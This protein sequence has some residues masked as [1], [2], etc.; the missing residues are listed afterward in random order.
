MTLPTPVVQRLRVLLPGGQIAHTL[1]VIDSGAMLSLLQ[2]Q[3]EA[4]E[5]VVL[6]SPSVNVAADAFALAG[7]VDG[8]IVIASG[9]VKE[10][11]SMTC[12]A[13]STRLTRC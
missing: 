12:A 8:V 13:G 5:F 11:R 4:Y 1:S 10:G 7:H 6:D 2:S 3:R 9:R